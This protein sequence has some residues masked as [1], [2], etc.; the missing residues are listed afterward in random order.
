LESFD[1]TRVSSVLD[2]EDRFA[3]DEVAEYG[4][5][6]TWRELMERSGLVGDFQ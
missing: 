4:V 1:F 5:R 6:S 3:E 2:P